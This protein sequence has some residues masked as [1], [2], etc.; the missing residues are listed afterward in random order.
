MRL[1]STIKV[2]GLSHLL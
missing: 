1:E 2:C